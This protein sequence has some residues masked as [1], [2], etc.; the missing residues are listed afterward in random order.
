MAMT[1][2]PCIVCGGVLEPIGEDW[3]YMQP[4]GGGEVNLIFTYGS[5]KF[6]LHIAATIFR[7]V[8]CDDCAEK[9]MDRLERTQ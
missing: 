2:K 3:E 1:G 4:D 7:G 5:R 8:I 6:D 9:M